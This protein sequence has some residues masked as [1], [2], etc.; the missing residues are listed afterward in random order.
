MRCDIVVAVKTPIIMVRESMLSGK[1]VS[2]F[3]RILL[4]RRYVSPK[5]RNACI[6]PHSVIARKI[7]ARGTEKYKMLSKHDELCERS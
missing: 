5:R 6:T 7:R 4:W 3:R 2:V 1:R